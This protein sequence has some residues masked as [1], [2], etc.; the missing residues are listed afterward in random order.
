MKYVV[1]T[2]DLSLKSMNA[3]LCVGCML[4]VVMEHALACR[5]VRRAV[6]EVVMFAHVTDKDTPCGGCGG[7]EISNPSGICGHGPDL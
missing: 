4:T 3:F 5:C 1:L 2:K 7:A 6:V